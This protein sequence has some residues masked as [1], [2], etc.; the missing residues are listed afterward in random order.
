[1]EDG[2]GSTEAYFIFPQVWHTLLLFQCGW[3][4]HVFSINT[5]YRR[6]TRVPRLVN[7][8]RKTAY[9]L[10]GNFKTRRPPS[11]LFNAQRVFFT[12]G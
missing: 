4:W 7:F 10:N 12:T 2:S 1:M 6:G 8:G 5:V 3:A 11:L 9:C